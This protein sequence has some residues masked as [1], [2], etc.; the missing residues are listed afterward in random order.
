MAKK[1]KHP[2]WSDV[3]TKLAECL[4]L[5]VLLNKVKMTEVHRH[6]SECVQELGHISCKSQKSNLG[7]QKSHQSSG[8]IS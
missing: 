3:E 5:L 4:I 6:I 8:S 2:I 1:K 7:L